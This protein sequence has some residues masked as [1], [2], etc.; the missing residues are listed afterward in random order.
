MTYGGKRENG[1]I[2]HKNFSKNTV[3]E[4]TH[5]RCFRVFRDNEADKELGAGEFYLPG[6]L[7]QRQKEGV[8]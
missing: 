7:R 3:K 1:A 5:Y 8:R 2:Y 6:L 4:N